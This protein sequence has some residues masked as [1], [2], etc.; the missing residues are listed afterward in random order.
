MAVLF[1][2]LLYVTL[3]LFWYCNHLNGVDYF[4]FLVSLDGWAAL[5]R[6][7]V[8]LFGVCDCGISWSYSLFLILISGFTVAA[9]LVWIQ[10][11]DFHNSMSNVKTSLS[12][13]YM[14]DWAII[15]HV[16]FL[17]KYIDKNNSTFNNKANKFNLR[18]IQLCKRTNVKK[19]IFTLI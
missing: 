6:G 12:L 4:V 3:C 17:N 13:Y 11:S 8:G 1:Y 14:C 5:P 7:A 19:L 2:V 10:L 16:L 15:V 18:Y 9:Y